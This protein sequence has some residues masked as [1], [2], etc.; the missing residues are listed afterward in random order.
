MT[1]NVH[2]ILIL[3][4]FPQRVSCVYPILS[5]QVPEYNFLKIRGCEFFKVVVIR[6]CHNGKG[7]CEHICTNGNIPLLM[8]DVLLK[9]S[10]Q[11]SMVEIV[12]LF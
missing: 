10:L 5:K 6:N 11:N 2:S 3:V 1:G 7:T 8:G 12:F 4:G 9:K